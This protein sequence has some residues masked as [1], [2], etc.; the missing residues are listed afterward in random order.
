MHWRHCTC[1]R[2]GKFASCNGPQPNWNLN[3]LQ[4]VSTRCWCKLQWSRWTL[5]V[6][7]SWAAWCKVSGRRPT[8]V[9]RSE[10]AR[11]WSREGV[12]YS[13][14]ES[15]LKM[16]ERKLSTLCS[17][18]PRADLSHMEFTRGTHRKRL[19]SSWPTTNTTYA[20]LLS[21][22]IQSSWQDLPQRFTYSRLKSLRMCFGESK[23]EPINWLTRENSMATMRL[24]SWEP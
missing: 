13:Q 10:C 6:Q 9:W 1:L 8:R 19:R 23:G 16:A 11:I 15:I 5:V 2:S 21:K 3:G 24:I 17:L 18:S 20:R 14:M 4:D 22:L 12:L 7:R